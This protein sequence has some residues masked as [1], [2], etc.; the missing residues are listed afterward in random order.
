MPN[1][2]STQ[3]IGWEEFV[4]LCVLEA[5]SSGK[6]TPIEDLLNLELRKCRPILGKYGKKLR[7][8]KT[9]ITSVDVGDALRSLSSSGQISLLSDP[10]AKSGLAAI[11]KWAS[12]RSDGLLAIPNIPRHDAWDSFR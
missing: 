4:Q 2:Q 3:S 11:P 12:I 10:D 7:E 1:D 6:R 5:L 9:S 8:T